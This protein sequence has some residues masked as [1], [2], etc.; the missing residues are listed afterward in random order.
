MKYIK[1]KQ[2][3]YSKVKRNR[4]N[5]SFIVIH[6]T[7]VDEDTAENE[8]RYF[9]TGNA[10]AAGAHF[11]IGQDGTIIK[12]VPLDHAAWSVG[13]RRYDNCVKTGGG[14]YYGICGNYNSVSIELCDN[15]SKNPSKSQ[16]KAVKKCIK[17][18]QKYCKNAKIVIRHFDV[19]GKNCPARMTD[20]TEAGKQRWQKFKKEI[21]L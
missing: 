12:S 9:A 2:I 16:V 10:R 15:K 5:I 1:A 4:K 14:S 21:T 7:G 6:Y 8:A 17:Y 18:I 20:E 13:G 19:T 3:S 11:F